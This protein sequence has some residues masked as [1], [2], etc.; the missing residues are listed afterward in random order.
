MKIR[1]GYPTIKGYPTITSAVAPTVMPT[2]ARMPQWPI[3]GRMGAA[4]GGLRV[5]QA[6][7]CQNPFSKFAHTK[8]A[9]CRHLGAPH[10]AAAGPGPKTT[11]RVCEK[12]RLKGSPGE[13]SG[14]SVINRQNR[15]LCVRTLPARPAVVKLYLR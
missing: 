15:A 3:G 12:G 1:W 10:P 8:S 14:A 2:A 9:P 7:G 5:S 4:N 13:R 6:A 11:S